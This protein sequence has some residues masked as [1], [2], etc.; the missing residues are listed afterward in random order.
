MFGWTTGIAWRLVVAGAL[1]IG[2][3]PAPAAAPLTA[4]M[5]GFGMSRISR[6]FGLK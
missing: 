4:A 1:L 2:L 3:A 5:I 6:R